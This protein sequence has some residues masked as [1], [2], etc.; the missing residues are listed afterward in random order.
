[1]HFFS[2]I[3]A[4]VALSLYFCTVFNRVI[5]G[6]YQLGIDI[7]ST[8]IKMALVNLSPSL[9]QGEGEKN[10]EGKYIFSLFHFHSISYSIPPLVGEVRRGLSQ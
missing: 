8:T 5:K 1:M 6:M 4:R 3:L 9:S 10:Q 2:A 7:G